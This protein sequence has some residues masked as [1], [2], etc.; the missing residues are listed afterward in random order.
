ML[1]EGSVFA[2]FSDWDCDS[3]L[4]NENRRFFDFVVRVD[5]L[6]DAAFLLEDRCF[7]C[8]C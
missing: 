7:C 6:A 3:V 1:N 4:F 5:V 2:F 8:F